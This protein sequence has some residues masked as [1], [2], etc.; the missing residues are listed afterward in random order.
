MSISKK[1]ISRGRGRSV[2]ENRI[3]PLA[4]SSEA[5]VTLVLPIGQQ[6]CRRDPSVWSSC[7]KNT[8]G[9]DAKA[10][11]HGRRPA[12]VFAWFFLLVASVFFAGCGTSGRA[13]AYQRTEEENR[14]SH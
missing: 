14:Q 13:Q 11:T 3:N 9:M 2:H 7:G 4:S 1:G 8:V 6:Q 12:L 5:S 10:N